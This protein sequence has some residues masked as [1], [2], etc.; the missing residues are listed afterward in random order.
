MKRAFLAILCLLL[1]PGLLAACGE[2]PAPSAPAPVSDDPAAE[3][4]QPSAPAAEAVPQEDA[5]P[6]EDAAA[7]EAPAPAEDPVTLRFDP[8]PYVHTDDDEYY[9]GL[10]WAG[11]RSESPV[12]VT[13]TYQVFDAEGN[14]ISAF[15]MMKGRREEKFT[16]SVFIPAGAE[17]LPIGFVLASGLVY[18]LEQD[19]QQAPAARVDYELADWQA[20]PAEDLA[21]HFTPGELSLDNGHLTWP[22]GFDE[23]ISANYSSVY[24]DYTIL[25]YSGD[26]VA[27]VCCRN[28][29]P[30]G[31]SSWSVSYALE[32]GGFFMAYHT[33]PYDRVIDRWEIFP[34]C[35]AAN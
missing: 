29:Y 25:G 1:I 35:F 11:N 16:A 22:I 27:A 4:P 31:N 32:N 13:F 7:E 26:Q 15:N 5:A 28:D 18:D 34:G 12:E 17:E 20:V 23:T 24:A 3:A 10:V 6:A 8:Q 9:V 33:V 30:Y 14:P 19:M 2:S 21:A